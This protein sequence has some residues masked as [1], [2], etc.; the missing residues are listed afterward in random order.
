[1]VEV[2][3]TLASQVLVEANL[4]KGVLRERLVG[5]CRRECGKGPR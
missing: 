4:G 1:M 3:R 5:V 2:V